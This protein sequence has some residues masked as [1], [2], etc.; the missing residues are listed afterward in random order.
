MRAAY[1]PQVFRELT[2]EVQPA[3]FD[4]VGVERPATPTSRAIRVNQGLR[5]QLS[6]PIRNAF[7]L[8]A[9]FR[10]QYADGARNVRLALLLGAVL[11]ST[12]PIFKLA[13]QVR[14]A[15]L[16]GGAERARCVRDLE[17]LLE[18]LLADAPLSPCDLAHGLDA[19]IVHLV[20]L[21]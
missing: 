18:M 12:R 13:D 14:A 2:N 21:M 9:E 8:I 11:L 10:S 20:Q 6:Q 4:R 16:Q 1:L 17:Q 7:V 15:D 3:D 19:L 5:Q